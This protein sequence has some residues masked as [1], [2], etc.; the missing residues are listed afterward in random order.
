MARAAA[1]RSAPRYE[2]IG[3]AARRRPVLELIVGRARHRLEAFLLL[4]PAHRPGV[5]AL[6]PVHRTEVLGG[7]VAERGPC[8][9]DPRAIDREALA[10][11]ALVHEQRRR[12]DDAGQQ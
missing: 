6:D 3:R 7:V 2:L 5:T 1:L 4:R 8:R 11:G 10:V 9:L 12:S